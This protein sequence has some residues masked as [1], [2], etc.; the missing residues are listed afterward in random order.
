[1]DLDL[2]GLKLK[3]FALPGD[4]FV[5]G[6]DGLCRGHGKGGVSDDG[7]GCFKLE[8]GAG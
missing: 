4:V 1:M 2:L 3:V 5:D 8:G 7:V 6:C